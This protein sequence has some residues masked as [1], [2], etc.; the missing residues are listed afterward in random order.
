VSFF[1]RNIDLCFGFSLSFVNNY[2]SSVVQFSFVPVCSVKQMSLSGSW[3]CSDGW[4][5]CF[6]M[7]PSLISS[8]FRNLSFRMC[9]NLYYLSVDSGHHSSHLA[10]VSDSSSLSHCSSSISSSG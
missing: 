9:H 8:C 5:Y 10:S 4:C 7:C 6:V 1:T 3:T 2:L